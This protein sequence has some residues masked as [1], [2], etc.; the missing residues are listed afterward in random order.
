[1]DEEEDEWR[2]EVKRFPQCHSMWECDES[3]DR[4]TCTHACRD[5]TLALI[6]TTHF[7]SLG[8]AKH[9]FGDRFSTPTLHPHNAWQVGESYYLDMLR[10]GSRNEAYED[11]LRRAIASVREKTG[12][13]R[14]R[15]R[16]EK[17]GW[18]IDWWKDRR[19]DR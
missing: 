18:L 3:C 16:D 6:S 1:M 15:I 17:I 7:L 8:V 4:K 2:D 19:M 13:Q 10:D 11:G 5:L 9:G 14:E 12:P